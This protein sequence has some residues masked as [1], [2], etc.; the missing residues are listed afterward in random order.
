MIICDHLQNFIIVGTEST[1][2][3]K[4][5]DRPYIRLMNASNIAKFKSYLYWIN[6][7]CIN[8]DDCDAAYSSFI[9]RITIGY[10]QC[11]PL[12]N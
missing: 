2:D 1:N 8:T 12:Y 3:S 6:W 7:K 4:H 10:E 11:S 9:N 5:D